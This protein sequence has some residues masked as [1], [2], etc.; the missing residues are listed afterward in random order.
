MRVAVRGT[1]GSLEAD[2]YQPYLRHEGPP[3]VGKWSPVDL[4]VQGIALARGGGRNI[5]DRLLQHGTYHGM[6]RMLAAL[7]TALRDGGPAP[8]TEQD[9]MA[10]A[11]LIDRIVQLAEGDRCGS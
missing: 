5:R 2:M 10:S 8:V 11:T 6:G 1:R 3:W 7:Y 9:L 4:V